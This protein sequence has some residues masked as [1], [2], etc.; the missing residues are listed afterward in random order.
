MSSEEQFCQKLLDDIENDRLVL[1]TLPEVALRIRE[2]MDDPNVSVNRLADA[3][4]SDAA[5]S[6]RLIRV[7]N[8]ALI[9]GVVKVDNLQTAITRMGL[10]FVRNLATGLAMEQMFQAT[11]DLV[12]AK[13]REVWQHSI[14]VAS[15]CHV[16]AK[17]YTR[18]PPD[19]ATLI[20][21]V[22]E[23]GILPI[24]TAAEERPDFLTDAQALDRIIAKIHP[25]IGQAIL[26]TW[27]FPE[28]LSCVPTQY[29]EFSR[30]AETPD[31]ADI[32]T[33]ASLQTFAG[34]NHP[35]AQ[36]DWNNVSSFHRLG[37]ASDVEVTEIEGISEEVEEAK[38]VLM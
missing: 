5:L 28:E 14:E 23:I 2:A 32:V 17:H 18:L 16:L 6:A 36:V 9:R 20:G 19:Q 37:L 15:I 25:R 4:S 29:L 22:H 34:S 38:E 26:E 35:L 30:D 33:V 7:A 13:L 11:N 31:Y 8:S 27:G 10:T 12:D 21:L 3:I 24:L 1:P